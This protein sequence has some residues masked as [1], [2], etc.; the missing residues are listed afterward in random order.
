MTTIRWCLL[1]FVSLP[2]VSQPLAAEETWSLS[3]DE[4]QA[5]RALADQAVAL[6]MPD[7]RGATLAIGELVLKRD[8]FDPVRIDGLHARRAD[9]SWLAQGHLTIDPAL[10][11]TV[12]AGKTVTVTP[13]QLIARAHGRG[14]ALLREE[15]SQPGPVTLRQWMAC[16]EGIALTLFNDH[17]N[18]D[19]TGFHRSW[20]QPGIAAATTVMLLRCG[21]PEAETC[22]V[23]VGR[24]TW[25]ADGDDQGLIAPLHLGREWKHDVRDPPPPVE[26]LRRG[27]VAWFRRQAAGAL[28]SP[29]L[30]LPPARAAAA[31][32]TLL[33]ADAT[34]ERSEIDVLLTLPSSF[35]ADAP[36]ADRLAGY[37]APPLETGRD[38]ITSD[39]VQATL[40]NWA[41]MTQA[42]RDAI[43]AERRPVLAWLLTQGFESVGV[44]DLIPLIGDSRPSRWLDRGHPRTIGDQ[45]LRMIAD[46]LHVDPR[47][48]TSRDPAAP[49]TPDE[50]ATVVRE[51]TA[52]WRSNSERPLEDDLLDS[53]R[54][55]TDE[56][57][58]VVLQYW[59]PDSA[60][61]LF[62]R[63]ATAWSDGPPAGFSMATLGQLLNRGSGSARFTACVEHWTP[64]EG[65][66]SLLAAWQAGRGRPQ[67]LDALADEALTALATGDAKGRLDLVLIRARSGDL[68]RLQQLL[69]AD[70]RRIDLMR[71]TSWLTYANGPEETLA[72]KGDPLTA[73]RSLA[74]RLLLAAQLITD[75]RPAPAAMIAACEASEHWF[76]G[77]DITPARQ[78]KVLAKDLRVADLTAN[79]AVAL[80]GAIG[81]GQLHGLQIDGPPDPGGTLAERDQALSELMNEIYDVLPALLSEVGWT[82]WIPGLKP[83]T[84]VAE[85]LDVPF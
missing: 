48:F 64:T 18:A 5:I 67:A 75:H 56:E 68:T 84:T 30:G 23:G 66:R 49:W 41:V 31:A 8:G 47:V 44:A 43:P 42:Q 80:I 32:K 37:L 54:R 3:V 24:W 36:L 85:I 12:D 22:A 11:V 63:L 71:F 74:M 58:L 1:L 59:F 40:K 13:Q 73:K 35:S 25:M 45:A 15:G 78:S 10:V 2:L 57:T 62:D 70:P 33:P 51:L 27:L 72:L 77:L 52:W 38:Q 21:V 65:L 20:D 16:A 76:E 60:E 69:S 28:P 46:R 83:P 9:G 55:L 26:A 39:L 61:L 4:R 29:L 50:R 34:R 82:V 81:D 6:G 79:L 53:L 14:A 17:G 7:T 19:A